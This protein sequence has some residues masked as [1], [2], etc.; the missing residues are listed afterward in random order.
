MQKIVLLTLVASFAAC[1]DLGSSS[2]E[3][4]QTLIIG[5]GPKPSVVTN[6]HDIFWPLA[7]S[8]LTPKDVA[9]LVSTSD[10]QQLVTLL[11]ACALSIDQQFIVDNN[12]FFGEAGLAP[13]WP[14]RSLRTLERPAVS[15]CVLAHLSVEG[16]AIPVSIL[17]SNS[18]E[19]DAFP[20]PEG[21]FYGDLFFPQLIWF[22]CRGTG[23]SPAIDDRGCAEEDP[24]RPG[25]SRCGMVFDGLCKNVCRG[26][27]CNGR[28]EAVFTYVS[29]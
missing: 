26:N 1:Q 18:T 21:A 9:S 17:F 6:T 28:R 8:P 27:T 16:L 29:R 2:A 11:V 19:R 10:G 12:T 5:S 4:T 23:T 14:L 15:A 20:I 25:F 24:Q 7:Y 22:A 3:S 13:L